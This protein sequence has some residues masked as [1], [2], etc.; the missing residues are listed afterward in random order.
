VGCLLYVTTY[1]AWLST[2][3]GPNVTAI[4]H[5]KGAVH[6]Q[7]FVQFLDIFRTTANV[8]WHDANSNREWLVG[9]TAMSAT[10]KSP[11]CA[12]TNKRRRKKRARRGKRPRSASG[13]LMCR[14]RWNLPMA[15]IPDRVHHDFLTLFMSRTRPHL[16][17]CVTTDSCAKSKSHR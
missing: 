14:V 16:E 12:S 1:S 13:K 2:D 4:R 17:L 11:Q 10:I 8:T 6:L 15:F 9:A 3:G 7:C 5:A